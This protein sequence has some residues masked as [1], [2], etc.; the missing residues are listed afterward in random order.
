[1]SSADRLTVRRSEL[2][3]LRWL[4]KPETKRMFEERYAAYRSPRGYSRIGRVLVGTWLYFSYC[5][6]K[7]EILGVPSWRL[8]KVM[9]P[10]VDLSRPRLGD[11][12]RMPVQF[13]WLLLFKQVTTT[14]PSRRRI[15]RIR[16]FYRLADLRSRKL[17]FRMVALTRLTMRKFRRLVGGSDHRADLYDQPHTDEAKSFKAKGLVGLPLVLV[18]VVVTFLAF[19]CVTVPF[20]LTAQASFVIALVVTALI[21]RQVPGRYPA[22]LLMVLSLIVSFRYIWWRVSSTLNFDDTLGLIL[23]IILMLAEAYAWL[24]LLLGYFQ[25]MW[26]LRRAPE[27]LPEDTAEWPTIDLMIP[28]YNE[29]LDVVRATVYA[30]LGLD[31]P[32]EKLRI[33]ILDDGKRDSFRDFAAGVGVNYIRR[34]TNEHAKAGN[35]NH[36]LKLTDAEYVAIFDCD[37]IPTR[38]FFQVAMGWFLKDP[39]LALVQTPHHFYSP[40]AFERNLGNFRKIPNEGSLFYGITQDGNDLWNAS[41]FCGSC[42]VM[43]RDA[44]EEV[45]GIAVETVTEDAHTSLRLHRKGYNSAYLRAPVSAGLATETLS[46]HVGQRI[47]W[48]RGMAQIMRL[49]NPLSGPGLNW[50][51]RLC[52]FNAMLHFLAGIP[53]LI[54]LV[55]PLAFLLLHTYIIYA[56]AALLLLY[57]IPHMVLASVVNSTTQGKYRY[58]F[59]GEVYEI[60]LAWYVARPTTVALFAPHKGKFN[61]TAKGG[62]VENFYYDWVISKPYVFLVLLNV[63]GIIWG[64]FRIGYGPQEEIAA[65]LVNMAWVLYN[66]ILLCAAVAVAGEMRQVRSAPRV[67]VRMPTSIKLPNGRSYQATLRDFSMGGLRV[68]MDDATVVGNYSHVEIV[69]Q[70]A[71]RTF[72]FPTRIVFSNNQMLGLRLEP[73][74]RQQKIDY[75]QCTFARADHWVRWQRDYQVDRPGVSFGQVFMAAMR[76]LKISLEHGPR[77]LPWIVHGVSFILNSLKSFAPVRVEAKAL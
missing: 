54:F 61:V 11:L 60:V 15:R 50:R 28:T 34:P 46:A 39:K 22:L 77:P 59:W 8:M 40:D 69:L 32:R 57:V 70:R 36:A 58:S 25:T 37:H 19:I 41:F 73:M 21:V 9:F 44:L 72:S 31:W 74:T 24:V 49:D 62:K 67:D 14:G 45:G 16:Q 5:F 3:V 53:R 65:V 38:A 63:A 52:Y 27:K 17:L 68:D 71:N 6:L 43:R 35:V 66:L 30:C 20:S 2:S 4:F 48:A 23:G 29:D 56:P 13:L 55:A 76:G 12:L 75:V 64:V 47:R 26:P 51:Q 1:M 18:L 7:P 10:H 42:A 33:H